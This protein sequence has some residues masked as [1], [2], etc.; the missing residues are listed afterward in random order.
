MGLAVTLMFALGVASSVTHPGDAPGL[1]ESA[2]WAAHHEVWG[3]SR[4]V[5]APVDVSLAGSPQQEDSPFDRPYR[6]EEWLSYVTRGLELRDNQA[7]RTLR[8]FASMP[9]R[10][11]LDPQRVVVQVEVTN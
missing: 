6:A 10:L 3:S 8:W 5:R 9:V 11:Q 4:T 1:R 2:H 7:V